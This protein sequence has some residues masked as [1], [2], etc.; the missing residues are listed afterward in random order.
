MV[1]DFLWTKMGLEPM[2]EKQAQQY[3]KRAR[4]KYAQMYQTRH[5]QNHVIKKN[6]YESIDINTLEHTEVRDEHE[7][8][9]GIQ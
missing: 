6:D 4:P 5:D 7:I 3:A 2:L 8:T 9:S 1:L